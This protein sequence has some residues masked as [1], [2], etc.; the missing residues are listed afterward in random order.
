MQNKVLSHFLMEGGSGK[1]ERKG[2]AL[3]VEILTFKAL[4]DHAEKILVIFHEE[5]LLRYLSFFLY[6]IHV[7]KPTSFL[8]NVE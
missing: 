8:K 7:F 5:I 2:K 4:V 1:A 3:G 6:S